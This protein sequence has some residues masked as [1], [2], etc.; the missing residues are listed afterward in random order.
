[1]MFCHIEVVTWFALKRTH[2]SALLQATAHCERAHAAACTALRRVSAVEEFFLHLW[3]EWDDVTGA[4]RHV[5][6]SIAAEVTSVVP[7]LAAASGVLLAGAATLL[8]SQLS[9]LTVLS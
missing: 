7:L 9:L 4:A 6:A 8:L 2:A 3:D 5:A 1:M